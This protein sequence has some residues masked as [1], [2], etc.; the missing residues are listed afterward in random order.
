MQQLTDHLLRGSI[1]VMRR[2]CGKPNCRCAERNGQL[3]ESP[4]LSTRIGG[5]PRIITLTE[6]DVPLVTA[7]IQRH[8]R[9]D[10]RLEKACEKGLAYLRQ[11]LDARRAKRAS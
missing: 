3:H 10:E 7:A 2:K 1:I 4:A 8:Q 11:T 5:A 9:A 6:A